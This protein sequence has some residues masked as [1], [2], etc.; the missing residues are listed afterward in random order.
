M[1][2]KHRIFFIIISFLHKRLNTLTG[3]S[4]PGLNTKYL[5]LCFQAKNYENLWEVHVRR[6]VLLAIL[7][8]WVKVTFTLVI[9]TRLSQFRNV[10]TKLRSGTC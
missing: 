1:V 5:L 6:N 9:P 10:A 7:D 2:R 8:Q 3:G 4:E